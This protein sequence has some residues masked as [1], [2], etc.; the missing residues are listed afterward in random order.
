MTKI[1]PPMTAVTDGTGKTVLALDPVTTKP[2]VYPTMF[3]AD[4]TPVEDLTER[5][6]GACYTAVYGPHGFPT[7]AAL[8]AVPD[9]VKVIGVSFKGDTDPAAI[10]K[11]LT[12]ARRPGRLIL[13]ETIHEMNRA[14]KNGG[15]LAAAYHAN[16]DKMAAVVRGLDPTG[17]EL[18]LTQTWM[19]YAARHLTG[20]RT[21]S[22]FLRDDVDYVGCDIEW[23]DSFGDKAYPDPVGLQAIGLTIAAKAGKPLIYREFAWRQLASDPSGIGLGQFYVRQAAYAV[24]QHVWAM[25]IYDT[26]GSTGAYRL[27]DKSPALA[28]AKTIIG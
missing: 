12:A 10:T 18:G 25:S 13:V 15:P 26:N 2:F 27:L 9:S 14:R 28:A 4:Y 21:W 16:Y 7:A 23:D 22:L 24:A 6:P 17:D 3:G 1:Q 11:S 19:G 8:N 5:Y 20:D